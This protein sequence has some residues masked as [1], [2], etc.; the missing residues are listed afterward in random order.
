VCSGCDQLHTS[1]KNTCNKIQQFTDFANTLHQDRSNFASSALDHDSL[2]DP[3]TPICMKH[4]F[5]TGNLPDN[6]MTRC[7]GCHSSSAHIN[8]HFLHLVRQH[9]SFMP[10]TTSWRSYVRYAHVPHRT[11][12]MPKTNRKGTNRHIVQPETFETGTL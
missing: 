2:R 7:F 10:V 1:M 11:A 12:K 4:P 8:A 9:G 3:T 6:S 5:P